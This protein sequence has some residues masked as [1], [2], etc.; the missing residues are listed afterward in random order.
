MGSLRPVVVSSLSDARWRDE[1]YFGSTYSMNDIEESLRGF[2]KR[3]LSA[4]E[5]EAARAAMQIGEGLD[6]RKLKR[7]R[8][9]AVLTE[10]RKVNRHAERHRRRA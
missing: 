8:R 5:L 6:G 3:D 9:K 4:Q 7:L 1:L 2:F 10:R